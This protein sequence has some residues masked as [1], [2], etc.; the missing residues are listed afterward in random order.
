MHGYI[1]TRDSDETRHAFYRLKF[2]KHDSVKILRAMYPDS[3]V[4]MLA[5]KLRV[6]DAYRVRNDL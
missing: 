2:G 1:E 6:W 3:T 5:R 4:P